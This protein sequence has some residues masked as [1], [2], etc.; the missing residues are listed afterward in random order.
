MH[1]HIY[2][3][4]F[5]YMLDIFQLNK[6]PD[7]DLNTYVLKKILGSNAGRMKQIYNVL[8]M[9]S[10]IRQKVKIQLTQL[11]FKGIFQ[12]V[13]T[14]VFFLRRTVH[15]RIHFNK[16]RRGQVVSSPTSGNPESTHS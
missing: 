2:K 1:M 9:L 7:K 5:I 14:Y 6:Y 15:E 8:Y 3:Y 16:R 13:T 11:V 4:I 10:S 12:K